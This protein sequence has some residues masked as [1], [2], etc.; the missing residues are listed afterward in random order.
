MSNPERV[1]KYNEILKDQGEYHKVQ[2][3]FAS[4]LSQF[5]I[6]NGNTEIDVM[7]LNNLDKMI[8]SMIIHAERKCS[9]IFR[10]PTVPWSPTI[11]KAMKN[12][13]HALLKKREPGI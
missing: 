7:E 2:E 3:K 12:I 8:T 10:K 13:Q 1:K 6:K 9:R 5:K 11:H 4:L